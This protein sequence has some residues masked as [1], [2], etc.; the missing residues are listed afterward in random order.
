MAKTQYLTAPIKTD[1]MPPGVPYIVGNEAA[2]RFSYYGM[3]GILVIF[4]T[5]YL[6]NASGQRDVMTET[7]ANGWYH[8]FV[9]AVYGLPLLGAFLADALLGKF[10]T[11]FWLSIVYCFGHFALALNDT[12]LGLVIG[13]GLIALGAGGIKPCVS[14]NVG[15]QFGPSNESLLQR[16]Y[17]WFYFSIN[18]GSTIAT[19]LIP[20]LLH[21]EGY[22]PRWAF[23]VPG[24]AML[25]ATVVF[26]LGRKR[27]VHIPP[28]GVAKYTR[29]FVVPEKLAGMPLRPIS[30]TIASDFAIV[31]GLSALLI[32]LIAWAGAIFRVGWIA[33]FPFANH[34]NALVLFGL[35]AL[36]LGMAW[37]YGQ[38]WARRLYLVLAALVFVA[39][40]AGVF[41]V[42][43]F[44]VKRAKEI[45]GLAT[46][47]WP[48]LILV[49]L[50]ALITR[51][52]FRPATAEFFR[53]TP[54][55]LNIETWKVIGNLLLPVPFVAM[56]W[57]LWQQNFSSWVKQAEKLDRHMFG[58]EWLPEQIQTV[59]PAF[60]LMML[61][62]FS[63][64]VYPLINKVWNL[65]P[66]RKIGIGLFVNALSFVIVALI[67]Q[68][69]DVGQH[70]HVGWQI[71]AFLVLTMG[72][73]LVS[74]THL[75]FAYTQ[76]PK[77]LKSLV[78][79]T[80]LGAVALGNTFTAQVNF[81]LEKSGRTTINADYFW[82]FVKVMLVTAVLWL[83]V[84]P[85][86]RGKTYIQDEAPAS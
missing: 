35:V 86:Y 62:L 8:T 38:D 7:E 45:F 9:T 33:D 58:H 81:Y 53:K 47:G 74:V 80:Y 20:W 60:V 70:P 82:F 84:S 65:T 15:D 3:N 14:A 75:E 78:M 40:V 13:L 37:Q 54:C 16:A 24:I 79:C 12:R 55:A 61:P 46:R 25:I 49:V 51:L 66:L 10:R 17:S 34:D 85:F 64:V 48:V 67:Q 22:G 63:Y 19:I 52:L 30:V 77:K 57:A 11:V 43:N 59:N 21:K 23:G 76:A 72:E 18:T 68:R 28:T 39:V 44:E 27:F 6:M 1:K 2:E 73:V 5:T 4:M 42:A 29:E 32:G 83:F 71:V 69:L 36:G 41:P 26:Y 50:A 56:F 31:A